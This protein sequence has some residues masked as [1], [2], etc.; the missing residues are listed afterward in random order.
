M[1]ITVTLLVIIHRSLNTYYYNCHPL[2]KL[3]V[4]DKK[5]ANCYFLRSVSLNPFFVVNTSPLS[6]NCF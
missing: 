5:L 4:N 6:E 2:S 3:S 1:D